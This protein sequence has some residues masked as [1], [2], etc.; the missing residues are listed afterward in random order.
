MLAQYHDGLVAHSSATLVAE[1]TP[2][3]KKGKIF[4]SDY[5]ALKFKTHFQNQLR[6]RFFFFKQTL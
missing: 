6:I 3:I 1:K 5:T 2:K 4:R